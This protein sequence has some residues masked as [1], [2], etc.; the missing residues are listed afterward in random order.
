MNPVS[1]HRFGIALD[2]D[3]RVLIDDPELA[4]EVQT[5]P[6]RDVSTMGSNQNCH[7]PANT[8]LRCAINSLF[9]CNPKAT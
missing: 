8:G 4:R 3:G 1:R 7:P 9:K 5:T 2:E 6:G